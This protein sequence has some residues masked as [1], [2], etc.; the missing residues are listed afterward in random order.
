MWFTTVWFPGLRCLNN[1]IHW[2][3]TSKT[4]NEKTI[5]KEITYYYLNKIPDSLIVVEGHIPLNE[6]NFILKDNDNFQTLNFNI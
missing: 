5:F 6:I 4:E 3:E 1:I 2:T